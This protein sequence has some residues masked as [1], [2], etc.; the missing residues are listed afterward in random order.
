M[1]I[2]IIIMI[3]VMVVVVAAAM[4]LI[5]MRNAHIGTGS[6]G[7]TVRIY[8]EKYAPPSERA[9]LLL[10]AALALAPLVELAL[11][12]TQETLPTHFPDTSQT[13]LLA[14]LF[15]LALPLTQ[16]RE[17]TGRRE[18]TVIT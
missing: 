13:P 18:P 15:E 2:V 4:V 9:A 16:V 5:V 8:I 3:I 14:P 17:F 11:Q 12:L 6:E 1:S 7:A 10:P